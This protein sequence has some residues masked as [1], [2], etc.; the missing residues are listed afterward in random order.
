MS[1]SP[2]PF[3]LR[4]LQYAIAVATRSGT[5]EALERCKDV[6]TRQL[7]NFAHLIKDLVGRP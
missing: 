4:Q 6:T 7:G 5:R 1:L 2:H 3:S